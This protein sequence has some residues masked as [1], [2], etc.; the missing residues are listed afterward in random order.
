MVMVGFRNMQFSRSVDL[1]EKEAFDG[2]GEKTTQ[3]TKD[4]VELMSFFDETQAL[5]N[6]YCVLGG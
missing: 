2:E 3:I 5:H 4:P 1:F 6:S